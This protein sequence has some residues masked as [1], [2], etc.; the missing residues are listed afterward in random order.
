VLLL[1]YCHPVPGV[2]HQSVG[3]VVLVSKAAEALL[4]V[5]FGADPP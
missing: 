5:K 3:G 4:G 1:S 2:Y